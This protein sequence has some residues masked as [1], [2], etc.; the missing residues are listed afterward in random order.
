MRE[1]RLLVFVLALA[2]P[3]PALPQHSYQRPPGNVID[4]LDAP[5]TPDVFLSPTRDRLLL[6]DRERFPSITELAQPMLPLAG[7]RINPQ[8][9]GPH[10]PSRNIGITIQ[11]ISNGDRKVV[12]LPAEAR[13]GTPIW[14][15]D[16]KRFS[17]AMF[18]PTQIELW[19][20]EAQTGQARQMKDI[21]LNATY[22]NPFQWM[23]DSRTLLCRTLDENRGE[24]PVAFATPTGPNIQES[25]GKPAPIRT[26]QDLLKNGH[27]ETL[28]E[29]Y[30]TS[31]LV[32]ADTA[33]GGKKQLGAPMLYQTVDAS[34]DGQHLLTSIFQKPFSRLL[35]ASGFA[36]HL[37]VWDLQ[38]D[39]VIKLASLPTAEEVPIEGVMKGP[40]NVRWR[41]TEKAAL[42][43]VEALDEGN[44][45]KKVP[46]RDRLLSQKAPF[47]EQPTEL[48]KVEHRFSGMTWGEHDGMAFVSDYDRDRRWTRTFLV[49]LD[50][51]NEPP[52]LIWDRSVRDRYRDPGDPLMRTLPNGERVIW[53]T[54][55]YIFL[56][57]TGA[58]ARGDFPFLDR[59]DLETLKSERVFQCES[60]SY[61]SVIALVEESGRPRFIT[62][63]ES[64]NIPPNYRMRIANDSNTV[65]LTQFPDSTPQLRKITKQL[66]TYKR[67]DGVPLSFTLY[68]PPG[69]KPGQRLP[70]VVWAYP[71]EY[72]DPDTAGQISGSTN[73]FTTIGGSSHLFFVLQGYAVL[74]GAT[75]PVVGSP[76]SMNDT[77][78]DQIVSSAKAA[79]DKAV[80]MGVTDPARVGVGGHSYGAFMTANLLAHSDLFRAGIARSGAY[81]RT[82]TPFGFQ[83]E[84]RTFWEAPEIY[85]RLSPFMHA[86][87]INEPILLIH[88]ERDDNS[89]TFPIQSDRLFQAIKG[90]GGNVRYVTLPFEAHGYAARESIEHTLYE[91]IS[92]FDR[93]V[94]NAPRTKGVPTSGL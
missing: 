81:N 6:V 40:R 54:S 89:G 49:K 31:Q 87:K 59:L 77:F 92:W 58:S 30:L 57:G 55:N 76:E 21:V 39:T 34:P 7:L 20:V 3:I 80:E 28:F 90:N 32:L 70:T 61:E 45:K 44:P 15:P 5:V 75:M 53:Q 71:L 51:T 69:Y 56:N 14:A 38:T 68:L 11:T 26:F 62:R 63:H 12:K 37:V 72:N 67:S 9:N 82:L 74:D 78:I 8:N 16:G 86:N 24:A 93:H 43:W 50:Q 91:M 41:P 42:F 47:Q 83:G 25:Y 46:H 19:V 94:K 79:I 48:L 73:R 84:R 17:F 29:Y 88:G 35:P 85:S 33:D 60:N 1:A 4:I 10:R 36:R 27:D 64:S 52:R 22:A 18:H 13:L 65:A 23:P 2:F 66:V